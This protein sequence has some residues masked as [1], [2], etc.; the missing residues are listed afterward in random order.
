MRI[1]FLKQD[2]MEEINEKT[3]TNFGVVGIAIA[4]TISVM[5]FFY[6]AFASKEYVEN[7]VEPIKGDVAHI[8]SQVDFL[9]QHILSQGRDRDAKTK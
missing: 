8:R 1:P 6:T 4:T 7:K 2:A 3:K 5:I 9:V